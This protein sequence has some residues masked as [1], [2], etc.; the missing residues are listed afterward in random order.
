[1]EDAWP[2]ITAAGSGPK[3]LK[4]QI[5]DLPGIEKRRE[6]CFAR[7]IE[8][9]G[10]VTS[11]EPRLKS[12]TSPIASQ[13][14]CTHLLDHVAY[15]SFDSLRGDHVVPVSRLARSTHRIA[16]LAGESI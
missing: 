2:H 8:R 11:W 5:K 16:M 10:K 6:F 14:L 7:S 13:D 9:A 1:M 15:P 3:Q 12:R 4:V